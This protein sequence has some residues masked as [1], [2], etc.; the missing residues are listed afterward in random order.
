MLYGKKPEVSYFCVFGSKAYAFVPAKKRKKL[1]AKSVLGIMVGY[2]PDGKGYILYDPSTRKVLTSCDAIFDEMGRF[3]MQD[4]FDPFVDDQDQDVL[5]DDK[6]GTSQGNG[7]V[8]GKPMPKWVEKTMKDS[9][10]HEPLKGRTRAE[11]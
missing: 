3:D 11:Q 8:K 2:V 7:N 4:V 6:P 1:D 10:I 5:H 9:K